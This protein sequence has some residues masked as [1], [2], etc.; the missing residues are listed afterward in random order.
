MLFLL[1]AVFRLFLH[2]YY[3]FSIVLPRPILG[4]LVPAESFDVNKRHNKRTCD[5]NVVRQ[6]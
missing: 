2:L 5:V 6:K 3:V 4:F 1:S